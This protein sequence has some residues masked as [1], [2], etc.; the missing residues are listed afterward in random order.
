MLWAFWLDWRS[1]HTLAR[2]QGLWVFQAPSSSSGERGGQ[3]PSFQ[4]VCC[5][6]P[7]PDTDI[8]INLCALIPVIVHKRGCNHLSLQTSST[9]FY[10]YLV[11]PFLPLALSLVNPSLICLI[12]CFLIPLPIAWREWPWIAGVWWSCVISTLTIMHKSWWN[13]IKTLKNKKQTKKALDQ[14]VLEII[15][16]QL[17]CQCFLSSGLQDSAA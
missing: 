2:L 9:S 13:F 6:S 1:W 14:T 17:F 16:S 8:Q 3:G 7:S 4:A 15:L 12:H 11:L 5:R 10:L